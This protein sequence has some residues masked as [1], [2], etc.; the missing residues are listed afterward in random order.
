[1]ARLPSSRLKFGIASNQHGVALG[2][3]SRAEAEAML[4]ATWRAACGP[5]EPQA[6]IEMCVCLPD[7]TCAR[8]KPGPGML[9]SLLRRHGVAA[10]RALYV[11]DLPIDQ[12]AAAD[13]KVRFSWASEFFAPRPVRDECG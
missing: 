11:G 10:E 4:V 8:R 12:R 9:Q 5:G 2:Q 13:A 6:L 7:A 3:L 1:L